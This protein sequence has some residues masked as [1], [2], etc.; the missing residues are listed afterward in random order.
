MTTSTDTTV[1]EQ[2]PAVSCP[3]WEE[4][5]QAVRK[6]DTGAAKE[7]IESGKVEPLYT[8]SYGDTPLHIAAQK[9]NSQLVD[10]LL[11][12][13]AAVNHQNSTGATPLHK[14]ALSGSLKVVKQLRAE[15][16]DH[17]IKNKAG[18]LPEMMTQDNKVRAALQ[19][20]CQEERVKVPKSKMSILI[21]KGRKNLQAII[22]ETGVADIRTPNPR[23]EDGEPVVIKYRTTESMEAAKQRILQ[24]IA[25]RDAYG[26]QFPT[27]TE[28][29]FAVIPIDKSKHGMIIGA[30]GARLRELETVW[31]AW[32][33]A[34]HKPPSTC[35]ACVPYLCRLRSFVV[36]TGVS[37][38]PGP[39]CEDLCAAVERLV[40]RRACAGEEF[41]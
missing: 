4:L 32:H 25:A 9:G 1:A 5:V 30:K 10:L 18:L 3:A 28:D 38:I 33:H 35:I 7:I 14:A 8:D 21:G 12:K 29:A 2:S 37:L 20:D 39:R 13:G 24:S 41:R 6:N 16:A 11:K 36:L 27:D 23:A 34:A 17:L 31:P 22:D 40:S 26:D 15:N 19:D